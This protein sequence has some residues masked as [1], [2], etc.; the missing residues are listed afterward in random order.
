MDNSNSLK[1]KIAISAVLTIILIG[2]I[3]YFAI[4]PQVEN[5]RQTK[6]KIEQQRLELEKRYIQGQNLKK[7]MEDIETVEGELTN[8]E[9]IYVQK[10]GALEFITNLERIA[11][12]TNVSQK[13]SLTPADGKSS[14]DYQ[15]KPIIIA[16]IGG[17]TDLMSYMAKL[18]ALPYYINIET[19]EMTGTSLRTM[20]EE[21]SNEQ[22]INLKIYGNIYWK[23]E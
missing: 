9:K 1:N 17:F 13:I 16:L 12:E 10:E 6:N 22:N 23:S 19:T 18:E 5:I 15:E 7:L 21:G 3:F 20:R 4:M 2:A 11:E 8:L 14:K